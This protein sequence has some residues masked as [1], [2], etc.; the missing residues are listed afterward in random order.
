MTH[1]HPPF[2]S[3]CVC[4]MATTC[5]PLQNVYSHLPSA[6]FGFISASLQNRIFSWRWQW[7]WWWCCGRRTSKRQ[8]PFRTGSSVLQ[9]DRRR[10]TPARPARSR[11]LVYS[12]SIA[13]RKSL[14]FF[15]IFGHSASKQVV[16][17]AMRHTHSAQSTVLRSVFTLMSADW[18]TY[19]FQIFSHGKQ[20]EYKGFVVGL[21]KPRGR[22]TW[23]SVLTLFWK[24]NL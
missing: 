6:S 8:P 17:W 14:C 11:I 9:R 3:L 10:R 19:L 18:A 24:W 20:G 23:A 21:E 12:H 1:L 16:P 22:R 2:V 7:W 13:E 15:F 4:R 5:F